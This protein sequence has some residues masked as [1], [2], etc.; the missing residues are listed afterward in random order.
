MTIDAA[1]C[2]KNRPRK[3]DSALLRIKDIKGINQIHV[4]DGSENFQNIITRKEK[5]KNVNIVV[6][7]SEMLLGAIRNFIFTHI[8]TK[9][10]AMIDDDIILEKGWIEVLMKEFQNSNVVAVSGKIVY[11]GGLLKKIFMANKRTTGGSGGAA[12]YDREAILNL[13]NFNKNIHRGEDIEL[14]LR[15]RASGKKW[16]KS[17]Q[18]HAFHPSSLTEFLNRPKANIIGWDFIMKESKQKTSFIL[19]R[20]A[21]TLIMPFYYTFRT[22][23]PRAGGIIFIYKFKSLY[24]YLT[25]KY[26]EYS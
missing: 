13:G 11:V 1:V 12:I 15:I 4:F 23:D 10:I 14:E 16:V 20:F 19:E 2:T 26:L 9:Y 5:H 3:V 24:Y 18:I 21:S 17:Q 25:K 6:I 8:K 22:L 7:P